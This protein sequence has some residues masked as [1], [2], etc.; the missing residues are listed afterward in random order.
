M[1]K[2]N[3]LDCTLRDGGYINNWEFGQKIIKGIIDNLIESKIDIIECGFIRDEEHNVNS[4]VFHSMEELA[5]VIA[6]KIPDVLYAVM[7]EQHN[8]VEKFIM[9]HYVIVIL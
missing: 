8:R 6:P 1:K 4:T 2:V 9:E 5:G 7:I 3:V